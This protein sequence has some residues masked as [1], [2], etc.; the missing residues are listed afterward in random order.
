MDVIDKWLKEETTTKK[1]EK[2]SNK[3]F[4]L[5]VAGA[6]TAISAAKEAK[7]RRDVKAIKDRMKKLKTMGL[8]TSELEFRL[9]ILKKNR[10]GAK[11]IKGVKRIIRKGK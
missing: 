4:A 8:S 7:W 9:D 11:I 2:V 1:D 3:K 6:V 5:G 10:P